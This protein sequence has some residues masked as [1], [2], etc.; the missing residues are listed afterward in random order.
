MKGMI[1]AGGSG[2]RLFPATKAIS[3]QLI[4]LYDKPMIYYPLSVLMLA[5]IREVL[6][7]TDPN[8]IELYKH[9]LGDGK[10]F[11]LEI[12]YEVQENPNGLAEAFLIGK[13]FIDNE[14]SALILGDNF[15][16]GNGFGPILSESSQLSDGAMLFA[17]R[18]ADPER[19]G[20]VEFNQEYKVTS[21]EEKPKNPKSNYAATG[22]YFYDNNAS[23][24]ASQLRPS[25]RG[26]L[27]ITD[28][29]K[30]YLNEDKLNVNLLGRGFT[31]LDTGTPQSMFEA[32]TFINIIETK[33]GIKIAC[34]EEIAYK[35]GWINDKDMLS[36]INQGSGPYLEYLKK[37]IDE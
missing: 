30:T 7:I 13:N 24:Y 3:K 12:S 27:E 35:K 36:F 33:Q 32:S 14:P 5:D 28:L 31:W 1:L 26:E 9:L 29:N 34:L 15:F 21:L 16:Y 10:R 17:Y 20:V 25:K 6:V 8:S 23:Y 19:F 37:V 18:V 22:L 2:T 4:P 11:G